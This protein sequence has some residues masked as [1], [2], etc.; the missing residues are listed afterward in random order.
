MINSLPRNAVRGAVFVAIATLIFACM[1]ATTKHL[2]VGYNVALVVAI[3][4]FGNLILLIA[5]LGPREGWAL[6]A[7]QRT[8][9]VLVR[10][11]SLAMASLFA[12]LA[13]QR[14]PVAETTALI[15]LAP[16]GVMLLAGPILAESV[17]LAGWIAA[18]FGFAGVL[19]I[20]RPG[21]GLDPWGVTFAM[22][23][24]A[25]TV[26]YHLL[27]R[28]LAKTETTA[29]LM[30]WTATVGT[31]GFGAALPWTLHG[32]APGTLDAI[33]F[34]A[35]GAMAVCGHFLFTA[36]FRYAPAS[37]LAPVNYLHLVWA[38]FLGWLIFDHMPDQLGLFGMAVIAVAGIGAA[39]NAHLSAKQ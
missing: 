20:V 11:A 24:A 6:V 30:F 5:I 23:T 22:L 18:G 15:F 31:L 27:S 37:A 29:A 10:G 28:V 2:A 34:I 19:L 25:V 3:R 14:M 1:D 9:L 35:L 17:G 7:T 12:G 8:G 38:G 26:V 32:G 13:L 21:S 4:Y 16:F 39:L 33:L 36:A